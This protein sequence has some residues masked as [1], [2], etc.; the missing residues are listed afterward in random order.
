M[1]K[2]IRGSIYCLII[3]IILLTVGSSGSLSI[4]ADVIKQSSEI[5][6]QSAQISIVV[7]AFL[8]VLSGILFIVAVIKS[9]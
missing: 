3:G 5:L 8:I 9:R 2:F 7:G 1:I 4:K 6:Y